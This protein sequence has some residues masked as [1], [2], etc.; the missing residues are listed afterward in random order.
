MDATCSWELVWSSNATAASTNNGRPL[1]PSVFFCNGVG[2]VRSLAGAAAG[3]GDG[4]GGG[5]LAD[6]ELGFDA[7]DAG[8]G[9]AG[10]F[11]EERF[12][13]GASHELERLADGGD[14]RDVEGG[15]LD[16]VEADDGDVVGDAEAGVVEGADAAHGGDVVEAEDGGELALA[17]D[18]VV[19]AG[20][21]D[22]GGGGVLVELD[23]ELAVDD[24]AEL[25]GDLHGGVPAILGVGADGLALHEDDFA[26][27]ELVEVAEGEAGGV[28]VVE[29]DVGDVGQGGV[30]GDEHGGQRERV[31]EVGVDGEDAVDA[32]RAEELGIGLDEVGL[33]AVVDGEVEVALLHE[34][35]ADAAEDLGVVAFAELGEED[36][37]GLHAL[38]LEGAGDHA[39]LVVELGGGGADALAGGLGDGAAG[40][41]VE[42][43]GDGGGAEAEVLGQELE[44]GTRW[45]TLR[46]GN[47]FRHGNWF[48]A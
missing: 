5:R 24:E 47:R 21:A 42:D 28:L 10:E 19:D 23:G 39:G 15:G 29:D 27:A 4:G 25:A 33:V 44:V 36:A 32:A 43:E 1:R 48:A 3:E 26:V 30:A 11:E 13:R 34:E 35:V 16:V 40:G 12:G 6:D 38:A 7:E 20:V 9:L 17:G 2:G 22:L 37:D 41:V 46:G 14:A 8:H 31:G 18:E 45:G